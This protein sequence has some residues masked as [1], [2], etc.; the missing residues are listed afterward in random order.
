MRR[1]KVA[2]GCSVADDSEVFEVR[3]VPDDVDE[4]VFEKVRI[5]S[6]MQRM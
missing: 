4:D 3:D 2:K 6:I 5:G 1:A